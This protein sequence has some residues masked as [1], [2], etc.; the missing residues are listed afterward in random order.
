MKREF[1]DFF[2]VEEK[3]LPIHKRLENWA[4]WC[5]NRSGFRVSPMFELYRSPADSDSGEPTGAITIHPPVDPLD[6]AKIQKGVG[7]L[8][9]PNLLALNWNYVTP[10]NPRRVASKIGV[11]LQGLSLLVRGGRQMLINRR[12]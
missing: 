5:R 1:I 6:A 10:S 11:S 8:P 7:L 9:G 4:R 12:A 3:H 2:L